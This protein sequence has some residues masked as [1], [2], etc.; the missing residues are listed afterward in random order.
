MAGGVCAG[1]LLRRQ[2]LSFLSTLISIL[3][4]V[5]LFLLGVEVGGDERI[6]KGM[7]SLGA[8]AIS[9][10]LAGVAGCALFAK[11]L[12]TWSQRRKRGEKN[13]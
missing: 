13:K 10:S 7:G 1:R 12:W 2:N 3:I 6:V 4:W 8:E 11:G 9:I 5:L